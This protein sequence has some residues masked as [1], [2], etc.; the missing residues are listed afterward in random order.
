MLRGILGSRADEEQSAF[1]RFFMRNMPLNFRIKPDFISHSYE[2]IALVSERKIK[3][4]A[5][6][7][8]TIRTNDQLSFARRHADNVIFENIRPQRV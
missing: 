7:C 2:G 1:R 3:G 5:L 6:L 8:W 4:K